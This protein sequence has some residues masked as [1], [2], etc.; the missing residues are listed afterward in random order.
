MIFSQDLP[1][2]L[3]LPNYLQKLPGHMIRLVLESKQSSHLLYP[4]RYPSQYGMGG[5]REPGGVRGA[6]QAQGALVH[7]QVRARHIGP[8]ELGTRR[9]CDGGY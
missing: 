4:E 8:M 2:Y 3:V 6:V 5:V 1:T 7:L 9:Q